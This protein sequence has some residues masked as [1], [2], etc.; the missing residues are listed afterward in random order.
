[1]IKVLT[2]DRLALAIH[3]I[4]WSLVRA[5]PAQYCSDCSRGQHSFA[6]GTLKLSVHKYQPP[7]WPFQLSKAMELHLKLTRCRKNRAKALSG[8]VAARQSSQLSGES[9]QY[10]LLLP[11]LDAPHSSPIRI[12]GTP[13]AVRSAVARFR[14]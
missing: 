13:C 14:T 11:S 12:I 8:D 2:N 7:M 4:G 10:V 9:W 1:M 3:V 5:T 6:A